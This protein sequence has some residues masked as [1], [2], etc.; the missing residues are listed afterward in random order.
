MKDPRRRRS[1]GLIQSG[2]KVLVAAALYRNIVLIHDSEHKSSTFFMLVDSDHFS[3]AF[4]HILSEQAS[5]SEQP[6]SQVQQ[7][8]IQR[9][10]IALRVHP[11]SESSPC[12]RKGNTYSFREAL[13][14]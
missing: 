11:A 13:A 1:A 10:L 7:A 8:F 6:H 9:A 12:D 2:C 3:R 5:T 14:C 4:I